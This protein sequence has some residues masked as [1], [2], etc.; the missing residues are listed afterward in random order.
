M[1]ISKRIFDALPNDLR[2]SKQLEGIVAYY[3]NCRVFVQHE[4]CF[5]FDVGARKISVFD[6]FGNIVLIEWLPSFYK[7]ATESAQVIKYWQTDTV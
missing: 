2:Y 7:R 1:R 6:R 3:T 4:S 5:S